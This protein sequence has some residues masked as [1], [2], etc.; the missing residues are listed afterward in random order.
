MPSF[1]LDDLGT[2][3]GRFWTACR[4]HV[5]LL[6]PDDQ[7]AQAKLMATY[8]SLCLGSSAPPPPPAP[9]RYL[10]GV[11]RQSAQEAFVRHG[12]HRAVAEAIGV[13]NYRELMAKAARDWLTAGAVLGLLLRMAR[14]PRIGERASVNRAVFVLEEERPL[15]SMWSARKDIVRVWSQCNPVAHLCATMLDLTLAAAGHAANRAEANEH[16][17]RLLFERTDELIGAVATYQAFGLSHQ[18]PRTKGR[19]PLHPE[20]IYRLHPEPAGVDEH[21]ILPLPDRLVEIALSYRAPKRI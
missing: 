5:V 8:A 21:R 14:H 15:R 2:A 12:G 1:E 20:A 7:A 19:T 10:L 18:L 16:I 3:D 11:G 9:E 6:Y 17:Y 4:L 13:A